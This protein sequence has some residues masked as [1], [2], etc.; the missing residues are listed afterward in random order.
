MNE[1]EVGLAGA[2]QV[3]KERPQPANSPQETIASNLALKPDNGFESSV[4]HGVEVSEDSIPGAGDAVGADGEDTEPRGP[5]RNATF[6]G[7]FRW[8]HRSNLVYAPRTS[9][10]VSPHEYVRACAS[11]CPI[12]GLFRPLSTTRFKASMSDE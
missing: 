1:E 7:A 3:A 10:A 5:T 6:R 2:R 9:R 11:P 8:V 4:S 12:A